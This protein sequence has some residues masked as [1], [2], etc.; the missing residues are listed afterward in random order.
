M[1]LWCFWRFGKGLGFTQGLGPQEKQRLPI[2]EAFP[3][4]E[5][6]DM[7]PPSPYAAGNAACFNMR[8]ISRGSK[9][10]HGGSDPIRRSKCGVS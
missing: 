2:D 7:E 3:A 8:G 6:L 4:V 10:G 9:A 5:K 1:W